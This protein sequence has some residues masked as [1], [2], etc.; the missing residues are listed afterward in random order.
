MEE[1]YH[2]IRDID[3]EEHIF[4]SSA[5]TFKLPLKKIVVASWISTYLKKIWNKPE[6]VITNGTDIKPFILKRR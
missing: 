2:Y 6:A 5:N 1:K 4:E 3:L